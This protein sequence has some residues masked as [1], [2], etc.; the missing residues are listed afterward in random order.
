M[1]VMRLEAETLGSL[2]QNPLLGEKGHL[3]REN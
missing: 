3:L 2:K 1:R